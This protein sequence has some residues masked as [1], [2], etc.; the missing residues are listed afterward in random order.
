MKATKPFVEELLRRGTMP[1]RPLNVPPDLSLVETRIDVHKAL[2]EVLV[3]SQSFEGADD[4]TLDTAPEW[5]PEF[6]A[7]GRGG[8]SRN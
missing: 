3:E 7:E 6:L 2:I 8:A 1:S 5:L 4:A